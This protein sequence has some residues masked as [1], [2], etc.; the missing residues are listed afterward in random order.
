MKKVE[1]QIAKI[2]SFLDRKREIEKREN[3]LRQ[4]AK[5]KLYDI[6]VDI[7]IRR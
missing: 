6:M 3:T 2:D 4:L 7:I 1:E 5:E